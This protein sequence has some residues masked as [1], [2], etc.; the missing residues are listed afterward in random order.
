MTITSRQIFDSATFYFKGDNGETERVTLSCLGADGEV[1]EQ[2][3]RQSQ[4]EVLLLELKDL[5]SKG[6][7]KSIKI[8][9]R[10]INVNLNFSGI[11]D[12]KGIKVRSS[13][14]RWF[15]YS[16]ATF[17][18]YTSE[19]AIVRLTTNLQKCLLKKAI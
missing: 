16:S 18:S 15:F 2:E 10:S 13:M 14:S 12:D 11:K 4:V 6:F 8:K 17:G 1:I 5:I 9:L 3:I 19:D 7:N